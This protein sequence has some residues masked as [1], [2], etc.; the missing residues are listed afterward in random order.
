TDDLVALHRAPLERIEQ[1]VSDQRM[2][3]ELAALG[4]AETAH[5]PQRAIE[6]LRQRNELP[7]G[8][9]EEAALALFVAV[10]QVAEPHGERIVHPELAA[11]REEV[12]LRLQT[13]PYVTHVALAQDRER[14]ACGPAHADL[15]ALCGELAE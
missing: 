15:F 6:L 4:A 12:A 10:E 5:L 14:P 3:R 11:G 8:E 13:Q 1:H 9:L 7:V 2:E